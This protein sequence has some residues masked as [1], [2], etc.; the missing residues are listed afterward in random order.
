[1]HRLR[2]AM[3]SAL[4][5]AACVGPSGQLFQTT[6]MHVSPANPAGDLPLPVVLGDESGLVVGIEQGAGGT[7]VRRPTVEV[8]PADPNAFVVSWLGGLCDS[9][10]A[11]SFRPH[12]A[13]YSL[14]LTINEKLGLGCP[15]AGVGRSVRVITSKPIPPGS[16]ETFGGG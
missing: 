1:M 15:A 13:G 9:D 3:S 4:L 7:F 16:I 14:A 2:V 12:E 6:L 10:A 11:I 8:D 5:I